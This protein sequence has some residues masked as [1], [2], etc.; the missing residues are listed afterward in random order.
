MEHQ[1][2]KQ[3]INHPYNAADVLSRVFF[4]Y[5]I[6]LLKGGYQKTFTE[7]DL[8]EVPPAFKAK[9]LRCNLER[10]WNSKN[11]IIFI[12]GKYFGLCY[13]SLGLMK[14]L[15]DTIFTIVQP[16]I[17]EKLL[18]YFSAKETNKFHVVL[19]VVLMIIFNLLQTIFSHNYF[20]FLKGLNIKVRTTLLSF[21][22]RRILTLTFVHTDDIS[23][24]RIIT[25]FTKDVQVI[26]NFID[27]GNELWI[28]P[29]RLLTISYILYRKAGPL[30]LIIIFF[31]TLMVPIQGLIAENV[32]HQ[33]TQMLQQT[34][35]RLQTTQETLTQIGTTNIDPEDC[36]DAI[37]NIRRKE[38][39]TIHK[40]FY[41]KAFGLTVADVVTRG[42]LYAF[43]VVYTLFGYSMTID[44][45]LSI[46]SCFSTL[47]ESFGTLFPQAV[48]QAAELM[49]IIRRFETFFDDV[50]RHRKTEDQAAKI[51]VKKFKIHKG[52]TWLPDLPNCKRDIFVSALLKACMTEN[53]NLSYASQ[54]PWLFSSTIRQNIVFR[55]KYEDNRYQ[56]VLEVCKLFEN[57]EL[58]K[59]RDSTMVVNDGRNLDKSFKTKINI[60]R[61]IYRQSQVYFFDDC[62]TEFG[63]DT[64]DLISNWH[65][66]LQDKIVIFATHTCSSLQENDK[67]IGKAGNIFDDEIYELGDTQSLENEE[68]KLIIENPKNQMTFEDNINSK[69]VAFKIYQKY[70]SLG[71]SVVLLLVIFSMFLLFEIEKTYVDNLITL[72]IYLEEST[73]ITHKLNETSSQESQKS[74]FQV[75]GIMT[76]AIEATMFTNFLICFV[77][78]KKVSIRLH[79]MV[80]KSIVYFPVECFERVF[81]GNILNRLSKDL[82]I[83]DESI[84]F[85]YR[86]LLQIFLEVLGFI[87][88]MSH[89]GGFSLLPL[90]LLLCVLVILRGWC[91]HSLRNLRR[92]EASTRST[93]LDYIYSTLNG[94]A[95]ISAS[96]VQ[97]K[98][99]NE[100]EQHLDLNNSSYF[101]FQCLVKSFAFLI[102]LVCAGYVTIIVIILLT[103]DNAHQLFG[104]GSLVLTHIIVLIELFKRGFYKWT[105]LETEMIALERILEYVKVDEKCK[106]R[107]MDNNVNNERMA[108][109]NNC[110]TEEHAEKRKLYET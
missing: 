31:L 107:I 99:Q 12:I 97:E 98:L 15:A 72:W 75:Y 16:N 92:L 40:L 105:E 32:T 85:V 11:G 82:S 61:T 22:Y 28:A 46:I 79:R 8:Y 41:L 102:D 42:S 93:I 6:K 52:L 24:G 81:L 87:I 63:D 89:I 88:L 18:S 83:I 14:F 53:K 67:C 21:T 7:D 84:I 68:C 69:K 10:E 70:L 47:S 17:V 2:Q 27:C 64:S 33:K 34:D 90:G 20:L 48:C 45:L 38:V 13:L 43:L 62:L 4:C 23:I 103:V 9:K 5:A 106:K 74:L 55:E 30:I 101:T 96:Q 39:Q 59:D 95:T 109:A 78:T 110:F 60:A 29:I 25:L 19:Y 91:L 94:L 73:N 100:F 56:K 66:F 58:L 77:F 37:C 44:T 71:G 57:L 50:E 86:D 65:K 80:F 108:F 49:A 51:Y 3:R 35:K 26:E 104:D 36:L 54:K 1:P 76:I